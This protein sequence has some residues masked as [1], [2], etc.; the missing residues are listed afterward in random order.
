MPSRLEPATSQSQIKHSTTEPLAT[1]LPYL[2]TC[3]CAIKIKMPFQI[4]LRYADE[5]LSFSQSFRLI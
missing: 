4:L 2:Y 5:S 3:N 1:A